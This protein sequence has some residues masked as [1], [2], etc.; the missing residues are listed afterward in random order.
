MTE[1]MQK[2]LEAAG[3]F[4]LD[5][6]EQNRDIYLPIKF[7]GDLEKYDKIECLGP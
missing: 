7:K 3:K 6:N 2:P 1:N 4:Y 5:Q